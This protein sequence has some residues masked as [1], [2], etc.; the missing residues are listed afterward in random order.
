MRLA[1]AVRRI[2][3]KGD[4]YESFDKGNQAVVAGGDDSSSAGRRNVGSRA[5]AVPMEG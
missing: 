5:D 4:K 3:D 1:W 2:A